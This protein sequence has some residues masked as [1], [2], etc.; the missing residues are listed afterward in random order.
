MPD[1]ALDPVDSE[2]RAARAMIAYAKGDY[3]DVVRLTGDTRAGDGFIGSSAIL[4]IALNIDANA[5]IG[6]P[7]VAERITRD[8]ARKGLL[9][10]TLVSMHAFHVDD[11]VV[12]KAARRSR[13]RSA[14][15]SAAVAAAVFAGAGAYGYPLGRTAAAGAVATVAAGAFQWWVSS[16]APIGSRPVRVAKKIL[17]FAGSIACIALPMLWLTR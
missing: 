9:Q 17:E 4:A 14:W 5:R 6:R 1:V 16:W 11:G 12:V 7:L 8:C 13:M 10:A 15:F 3:E 2:V